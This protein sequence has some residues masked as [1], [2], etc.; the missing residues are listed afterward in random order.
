MGQRS[1]IYI[2]IDDGAENKVLIPL[3]FQWNYA[4]GM[5]SR[6][7]SV[8]ESIHE[9]P[10]VSSLLWD[11]KQSDFIRRS[12]E[13][14][15]DKRS[16]ADSHNIFEE[17]CFWGNG[18][19]LN[20]FVFFAQDNN[21]GQAYID[22]KFKGDKKTISYCFADYEGNFLGDAEAYMKFEYQ[23]LTDSGLDWREYVK[24]SEYV[25]DDVIDIVEKNHTYLKDN[26]NLMTEEDL[27]AFQNDDYSK[28]YKTDLVTTFAK[29]HW[30]YENTQ[31]IQA[32]GDILINKDIDFTLEELEEL[33]AKVKEEWHKE[34][35]KGYPFH[36]I[37]NDSSLIKDFVKEK[38]L[39]K[40]T[41]YERF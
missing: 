39:E 7:Q 26:A 33:S 36:A 3:Y 21:D 22:V 27:K 5:I 41:E 14:N 31:F 25:K 24:N 1:Q 16:I 8:I 2:R 23:G 10:T 6:V 12:A 20:D 11:I 19:K 13:I 18:T 32:I 9:I 40:E 34:G 30:G 29:K 28:A 37:I 15:F 38:T 4:D 17:Y 35:N